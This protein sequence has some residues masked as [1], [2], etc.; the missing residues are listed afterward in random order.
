MFLTPG[1]GTPGS[2]G[3]LFGEEL[4]KCNCREVKYKAIF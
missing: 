2:G 4:V 1:T 3:L